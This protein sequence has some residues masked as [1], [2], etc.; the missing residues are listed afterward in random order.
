[1]NTHVGHL[2]RN[3]NI[4][5]G[6]D[7]GWGVNVL[8]YGFLD[9]DIRRVGSVNLNG[10]QIQNG[11]QYDTTASALQFKN[12]LNGNYSSTITATSFYNCRD[13]CVNIENA[14]NITFTNNVFYNGR[15]FG[16]QAI[17]IK[18]FQF[19]NNL[20]IGIIERPT[21]AF[22]SELIAC[23]ATYDYIDPVTSGVSIK[24]NFCLGSQGHGFAFPHIKCSE[25][26][27]NPFAGNTA[28]SCEIGFI[29][30][31]IATSDNCKAFS[32]I[33]AY[34]NQIGQICGPPSTTRLVF[35]NFIMVDNQRGATL[36]FGNGEGGSNHTGIFTNSYI[37]AISR[38]DCAE[39]YGDNAIACT[40]SIGL[41]LLSASA[42]GEILPAKFGPGFDVI[43]KQE[44]YENKVYM[45]NVTFDH[46]NKTYL[47]TV[48]SVCRD[49]F[50]FRGN[51]GA[52]DSTAD[53]NL[54]NV[55]CTN[56]DKESYLYADQNSPNQ[57]GW[58]GGCGD[59]LCTGRSNY[60]IVD[61]NGTFLGFPGTIIPNNTVI[62]SNEP[63]CNPSSHMNAHICNR[64]D[65]A[66]LVYQSI[67]ADF[68]TRI[69]WPMNLTYDGSNYTTVTNGFRE[70]D[71]S[72]K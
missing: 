10:V 61:W 39:C 27:T 54:F 11:G 7:A 13:W 9:G 23:F 53:T 32:Y 62:G 69:M 31:N 14:Q 45:T 24:N 58:F 22:G 30:N 8:V 1:M 63:N 71:W 59:I 60:L 72:G 18:N 65:L 3:I 5:P 36:K 55:T 19:N 38:P 64:T 42:N 12:V 52:F 48:G 26:E 41:R 49:N 4:V 34:A 35:K 20:F 37:S 25:L 21:M 33:N 16:V 70:W 51:G 6:P 17:G 44:L 43:C 28:G 2:N 29:F 56:C 46:F 67:A 66:V 68:N 50:V 15:V 40:N 57:I 47:G